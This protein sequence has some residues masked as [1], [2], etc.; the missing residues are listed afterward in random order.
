MQA[1]VKYNEDLFI[2]MI[3]EEEENKNTLLTTIE[4]YLKEASQLNMELSEEVPV[5][6]YE[7]LPLMEV[8]QS[9]KH[10]L[11]HYHEVEQQVAEFMVLH[12][13]EEAVCDQLGI[14][15]REFK[16]QVLY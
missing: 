1:I 15:L 10:K 6:G 4:E 12:K 2:G 13:R 8:Q 11:K 5:N 14:A 7:N 16:C 9:L 3:A